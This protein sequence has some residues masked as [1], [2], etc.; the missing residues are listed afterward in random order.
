MGTK[1]E[2]PRLVFGPVPSRRLGYSLGVD[3]L[4]FKTCDLD[5]VYCQLG[6]TTLKT[7]ERKPYVKSGVVLKELAAALK[8]GRGID[9]VTFSGSGEPTLNT[10]L[11]A[12]IRGAKKLTAVPVVVITNGT[13]LWDKGVVA[14]L[15]AAD[16]VLP[17]L[18]AVTEGVFEELNRPARGLPLSKVIEGLVGFRQVYPGKIWLEVMIVKG[19]NDSPAH[20]RRL[21]ERIGRIRPDRVDINSPVRPSDE[22]G[23]SPVPEARLAEIQAFLGPGARL[24]GPSKTTVRPA[25][26]TRPGPA[27]PGAEVFETI[28]RRPVTAADVCRSFGLHR[29]EAAKLLAGFVAAGSAE[30]VRRSGKTYYRRRR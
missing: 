16:A 12:M 11:G 21:K 15:M 23:V 24:V 18:D 28:S 2:P 8:G 27:D 4:P 14:D 13:L 10:E 5:C 19:F 30:A 3:A 29:A 17:S 1:R 9:C 26:G 20:L 22:A 25:G 7:L 6:G